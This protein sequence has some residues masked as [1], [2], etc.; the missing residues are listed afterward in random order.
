[1]KVIPYFT[2]VSFGDRAFTGN[3]AGVCLL[4]AWLDDKTMLKI[5]AETVA[6]ATAFLIPGPDAMALRWFTPVVEEEM[7]GHGTLAAA[8]VVLNELKPDL[9]KAVFATRAGRLTVERRGD[10]YVLDLPARRHRTTQR[11]EKIDTAMGRPAAEMLTSVYHIAVMKSGRDVAELKPNLNLVAQL[12]LPGLIVTA[13]G[14]EFGC[15]VVSRY[16]AP[17]KGIPEDHATGSAHTQIIP[18]WSQRLGKTT[19]TA[20]QLSARGGA[21]TCHHVGDR[22]EIATTAAPYLKGEIRI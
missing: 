21:M 10:G 1:M 17:A 16:F 14:D 11:S 12:D 7:C 18:Y 6:P 3:P 19:I 20:R 8:W 13:P 15:D 2:I 5:A 9:S 4:D 22:V